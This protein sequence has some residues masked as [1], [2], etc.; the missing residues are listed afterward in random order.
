MPDDA[1]S[2]FYL[3]K[4]NIPQTHVCVPA[5]VYM[6]AQ[7]YTWKSDVDVEC[8]SLLSSTLFFEMSLLLRLEFTDLARLAGQ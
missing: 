6:C 5:H 1:V 8:L 7:R 2:K 4:G 3:P